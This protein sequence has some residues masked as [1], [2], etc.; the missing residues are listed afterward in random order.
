VVNKVPGWIEGV[1]SKDVQRVAATYLVK[2]NRTV[3]DRRPVAKPAP[4]AAPQPA[5][6]ADTTPAP[7]DKK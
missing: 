4:A 1:T 6:K 7:T 5:N 3:I 2:A